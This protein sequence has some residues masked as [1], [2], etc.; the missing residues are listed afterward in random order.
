M[1]QCSQ[2]CSK[3]NWLKIKQKL[4]ESLPSLKK[5]V[6][7]GAL[8]IYFTWFHFFIYPRSDDGVVHCR[9]IFIE[10]MQKIE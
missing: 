5:D 10:G 6:S 8:K 4:S 1:Q 3:P 2:Y 9:K 7:V